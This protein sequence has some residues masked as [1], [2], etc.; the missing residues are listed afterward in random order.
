M[1]LIFLV[2]SSSTGVAWRIFEPKAGISVIWREDARKRGGSTNIILKKINHIVYIS[3]RGLR[4]NCTIPP[5]RISSWRSTNGKQTFFA[6]TALSPVNYSHR[7]NDLN[8]MKKIM[9]TNFMT[10]Y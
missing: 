9:K 10:K 8:C 1:N 2:W 7:K 4:N 6:S 3:I 5:L